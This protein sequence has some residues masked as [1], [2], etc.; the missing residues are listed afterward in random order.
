M[1]NSVK[2]QIATTFGLCYVAEAFGRREGSEGYCVCGG[3]GWSG[4]YFLFSMFD[5]CLL[6]CCIWGYV[7]R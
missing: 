3:I 4:Y 5:R 7:F 2:C 1:S 6:L